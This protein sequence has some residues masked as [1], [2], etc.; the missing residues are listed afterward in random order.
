MERFINLATDMLMLE[1]PNL[2]QEVTNWPLI[3]N[4]KLSPRK[5]IPIIIS[6]TYELTEGVEKWDCKAK[7]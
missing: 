2:L 5:L 4:D 6:H 7:C 3:T 1:I